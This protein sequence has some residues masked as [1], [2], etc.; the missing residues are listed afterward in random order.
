MKNPDLP[1]PVDLD[2]PVGSLFKVGLVQTIELGFDEAMGRSAMSGD[3]LLGSQSILNRLALTWDAV[4]TGWNRW[5]LSFGPEAQATMMSFVGIRNPSSE[6]LVVAMAVSV[7]ILLVIIGLLQRYFGRPRQDAL[8]AGYQR[9]CARTARAARARLPSEG[10]DEYCAAL[11][12]LRPDLTADI[13]RLFGSYVR[14]RYDGPTDANRRQAFDRAVRRFRP[15]S[16]P[17]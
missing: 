17:T 7:T 11:C 2:V 10:P 9:L 15:R 14:L 8:Q 6:Y 3:G 16:Q 4:N 13:R 1:L 12:A 5:V